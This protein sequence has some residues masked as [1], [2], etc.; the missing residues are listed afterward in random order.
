MQIMRVAM[1]FRNQ[2]EWTDEK[3]SN[4][5][6]YWSQYPEQYFT[7]QFGSQIAQ[8]LTPYLRDKKEIL[9]YGCG[10]GYLI[11]PLLSFGVRVTG[12]DFSPKSVE[13][14]NKRFK[15]KPNFSGAFLHT[16][17]PKHQAQF[18]VIVM[19]EVIEHLNDHYLQET[20]KNLKALL[21][22]GGIAIVTTPNDENLSENMVYCPESQKAFHRWQHVRS[23]SEE[24]LSDFLTQSGFKIEE[25]FTTDF[26]VSFSRNKF[27]SFKYLAKKALNKKLPH[28]V[29]IVSH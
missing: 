19:I 29:C 25:C 14:V 6:N 26:S 17:I 8:R 1:E 22:P 10:S 27:A 23:W 12:L 16:D 15:G 2:L 11:E 18:D 3:I 20:V 24:T 13:T 9:D 21:K 28:L 4:F 5:W 7:Y